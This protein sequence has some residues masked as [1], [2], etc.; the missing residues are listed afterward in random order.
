M[1]NKRIH[2]LSS[3]NLEGYLL[4]KDREILADTRS[5]YNEALQIMQNMQGDPSKQHSEQLIRIYHQMGNYMQDIVAAEKNIT[6]YPFQTPRQIHG[7]ASLLIA[8]L[9]NSTTQREEFVYYMQRAYELL[10]NLTFFS[11]EEGSER[12]HLTVETPVAQP[13]P[14]LAVHKIPFIDPQIENS[15]MCVMLRGALLPSMIVS[16]AIQEYSSMRY[17]TP[18]ALFRIRRDEDGGSGMQYV[19]DL[20]QSFFD[21]DVLQGKDLIFADPM[22]ATA[23]SLVTVVRY[24]EEQKINIRSVRF[25]NVISSLYG[26]LQAL[27]AIEN[28][29]QYILWMDPALNE[30]SFILPGL[31][32]A[33]DRLNGKDDI[34]MPRNIIQLI[35]D[36]GTTICNLYRSQVR[37]IEQTVL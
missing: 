19:L 34:M 37:T 26:A 20:E 36:Y 32:D 5:M 25:L 29:A 6:V 33:G 18:F 24:L 35:A 21:L 1:T 15:V 30:Q 12:H 14:H 16:K 22:N 23:G 17:L 10:C 13:L 9:R 4:A 28:I 7:E 11:G 8:K 2:I 31:G 27:R 3:K